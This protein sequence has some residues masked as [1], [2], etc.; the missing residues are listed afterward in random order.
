[1]IHS[2]SFPLSSRDSLIKHLHGAGLIKKDVIELWH[3]NSSLKVVVMFQID[4]MPQFSC[5]SFFLIHSYIPNAIE[6]KVNKDPFVLVIRDV[7]CMSGCSEVCAEL[8]KRTCQRLNGRYA[9]GYCDLQSYL[10][11]LII[12]PMLH[13]AIC[14]ATC[15]AISLR[16]CSTTFSKRCVV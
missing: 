10:Y 12:K 6:S 8:V 16:R 1:M 5:F 13:F 2:T 7:Y 11:I 15:L 4:L 14:L 9:E 3:N